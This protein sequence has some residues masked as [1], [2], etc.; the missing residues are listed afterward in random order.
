MCAAR[1]RIPLDN[2]V[3]KEVMNAQLQIAYDW[4]KDRYVLAGQKYEEAL[5]IKPDFYEGLLALGQQHFETAKLQWS[6][7]VASKADLTS[8]NPSETIQLFDSAEEKMKAA[9]IMWEKLEEHKTLELKDAGTRKM[10]ELLKR[11]RK[12]AG[13]TEDVNGEGEMTVDESAEQSAV[14]RSQIHLF[15]GNMLFERSQLEYKLGHPDWRKNIDA[16]VERFK[17]AGASETDISAVLKNHSSNVD[18]AEDEKKVT[19]LNTSTSKS[20]IKDEDKHV[21]ES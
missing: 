20:A 14:M 8:W 21:V 15:W 3:P 18:G 19:S 13:N 7:A 1:K 11:R 4:V 2:S 16:A 9:S 6:F 5:R 12:L 10:D 17:L